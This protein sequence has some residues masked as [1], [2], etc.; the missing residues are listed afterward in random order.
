MHNSKHATLQYVS[1]WY[2]FLLNFLF[3]SSFSSFLVRS[4]GRTLDFVCD[5]ALFLFFYSAYS[6]PSCS[7]SVVLLLFLLRWFSFYC[8]VSVLRSNQLIDCIE[9]EACVEYSIHKLNNFGP[10]FSTNIHIFTMNQ[11][12]CV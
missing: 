5:Y 8:S 9:T 4:F 12:N 2:L 11:S 1:Y 3:P 7:S 10:N 6:S